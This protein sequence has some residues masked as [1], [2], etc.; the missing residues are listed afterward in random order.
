MYVCMLDSELLPELR[1]YHRS[2][3]IFCFKNQMKLLI[4]ALIR[5]EAADLPFWRVSPT[6]AGIEFSETNMSTV[7]MLE[8]K[9]GWCVCMFAY[10]GR[11]HTCMLTWFNIHTHGR[12]RGKGRQT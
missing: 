1:K 8:P 2:Q 5:N 11:Q 3:I 9:V 6:P 7:C 10:E 12:R 4:V